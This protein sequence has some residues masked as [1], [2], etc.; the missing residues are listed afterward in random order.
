[1]LGL[2]HCLVLP[3]HTYQNTYKNVYVLVVEKLL[4]DFGA[5]NPLR[6]EESIL[7]ILTGQISIYTYL[8]KIK[9]YG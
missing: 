4:T 9:F 2:N 3:S 1:M 7:R 8:T 6:S 5:T